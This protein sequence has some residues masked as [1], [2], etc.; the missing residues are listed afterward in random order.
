MKLS[1]QLKNTTNVVLTSGALLRMRVCHYDVSLNSNILI[2]V[3][4]QVNMAASNAQQEVNEEQIEAK[5]IKDILW[6]PFFPS[7]WDQQ[8]PS[9][10]AIVRIK[11]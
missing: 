6:D 4:V 5:G 3:W 8:K 1:V 10:E 2:P 7:D 9:S 11:R